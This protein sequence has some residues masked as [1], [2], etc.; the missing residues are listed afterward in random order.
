MVR[1]LSKLG[2]L[3]VRP[4][5]QS[6]LR[7]QIILWHSNVC[8]SKIQLLVASASVGEREGEGC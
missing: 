1:R 3:A 5:A 4:L 8:W 2:K 6:S 7:S